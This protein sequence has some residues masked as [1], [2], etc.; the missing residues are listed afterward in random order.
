MT[1]SLS[2]MCKFTPQAAKRLQSNDSRFLIEAI[3]LKN[4]FAYY[5]SALR[6]GER[7]KGKKTT[8]TKGDLY[9]GLWM[10]A[11][12]INH[13]CIPNCARSFIGDITILRAIC[14]IPTGPEI[15]HQYTALEASYSARQE[16]FQR[17][18]QFECDCTL[19]AAEK[20][21]P[22]AMHKQRK[23]LAYKVRDEVL[24][25]SRNARVPDVALRSVERLVKQLEDLHE[26]E[27][28]DTLPRLF[29]VHPTIWLTE[30]HRAKR[31]FAKTAKFA[32]ELL[33][34]FGF[35]EPIKYGKLSLDYTAGLVNS[36]SF[37]ALQYAMDAYKWLGKLDLSKQSETE[38]RKFLGSLRGPVRGLR[39][40]RKGKSSRSEYLG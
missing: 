8:G 36:E 26:P 12:Y 22:E 11:A 10:R 19:C 32:M 30:A 9:T 18:W 2:L 21:S 35:I 40:L 34:N 14:D 27:I 23:D 33:R 37:N 38:A 1:V 7:I 3:R 28:Y 16:Q 25:G 15:T 31:N 17:N 29:L 39:M 13:S 24:K 6:Q 4:G 5:E 20:K